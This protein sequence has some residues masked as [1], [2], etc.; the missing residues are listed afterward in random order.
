MLIPIFVVDCSSDARCRPH[1]VLVPTSQ[2]K[3]HL[4]NHDNRLADMPNVTTPSAGGR[5]RVQIKADFFAA[6]TAGDEVG[7]YFATWRS[8]SSSSVLQSMQS[9]AVGRASSRFSPIS[10]PQLSQ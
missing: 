8:R 6:G 5:R 10:T 9:V 2:T 1:P 3:F 7:T 4:P